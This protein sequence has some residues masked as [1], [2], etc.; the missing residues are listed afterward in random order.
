V[1]VKA[2]SPGAAGCL[3]LVGFCLS[4]VVGST[5][6]MPATALYLSRHYP[7]ELD[8]SDHWLLFACLAVPLAALIALWTARRRGKLPLTVTVRTVTLLVAAFVVTLG[9]L[10]HYAVPVELLSF[11]PILTGWA[12]ILL[13]LVLIPLL[14]RAFPA[15]ERE[16]V[17]APAPWRPA[18]RP[19]RTNSG[20]NA[21][22]GGRPR[23]P[24]RTEFPRRDG[25]PE[26]R[27]RGSGRPAP[28]RG[29]GTPRY[30]NNAADRPA[31]QPNRPRPGDGKPQYRAE[32]PPPPPPRR[33][34][35]D[36]KPVYRDD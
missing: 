17:A 25:Q 21:S 30:R 23:R 36:G 18:A 13:F 9:T 14:N 8:K 32:P 19:N 2:A 24:R 28:P 26:Y 33:P 22:R 3:S 16:R 15:P 5:L 20:G 10:E 31:R 12:A 35:G 1:S 11:V 6:A 7:A 29:D 27:N 4:P 34:S